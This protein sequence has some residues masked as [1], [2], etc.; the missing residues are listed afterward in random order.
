MITPIR[1]TSTPPTR[2]IESF[3]SPLAAITSTVNSGVVAFRIE[4][5]PLGT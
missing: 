4:A 5:S 3:S 2:R 1:P